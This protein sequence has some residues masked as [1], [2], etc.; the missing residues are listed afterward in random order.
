MGDHDD[1]DALLVQPP[2]AGHQAV[3]VAL[4]LAEGWLVE[5]QYPLADDQHRR[6]TQPPLLALAQAEGVARCILKQA[7]LAQHRLYPLVDRCFAQPLRLCHSAQAE[8]YLVAHGTGNKLMLRVLE[9]IT[10]Q[11]GSGRTTQAAYLLPQHCDSA[12]G[13]QQTDQMGSQRT[14]AATIRP[15][16]REELTLCNAQVHP[17][18]GLL[19]TWIAIAQVCH[20]YRGGDGCLLR[21]S[22]CVRPSRRLLVVPDC[23]NACCPKQRIG[24]NHRQ[25]QRCALCGQRQQGFAHLRQPDPIALQHRPRTGVAEN[26]RWAACRRHRAAWVK[27][28]HPIHEGDQVVQPMFND[29]D[30]RSPRLQL[31]AESEEGAGR[32]RVEVGGRLV[33]DK[34][35]WG[36]GKGGGK[37]QPLLLPAAQGGSRPLLHARQSYQLEGVADAGG[38]LGGR[39]ADVLQA[40]S[41]LITDGEQH[42]LR[43]R[44]LQH[45]AHTLA[46]FGHRRRSGVQ[47]VHYHSATKRALKLVGDQ[48]VESEG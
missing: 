24:L 37:G 27:N 4:I 20:C 31:L 38:H 28:R 9:H 41:Y 18:Q 47:A 23:P 45:Q 19:P 30:R 8:G 44:V 35:L 39:Q 6:H 26:R 3:G 17:P 29:Q 42:D 10:H 22:L 40:K 36:E 33:E 46:E 48:A 43:V 7:K 12:L 11:A 21:S 16:Q 15:D 34:Q 1:R 13:G 14:L 32:N 2:Q 25:R 5:D